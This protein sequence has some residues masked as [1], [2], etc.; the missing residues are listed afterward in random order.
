MR[1]G[2]TTPRAHYL[3]NLENTDTQLIS[4]LYMSASLADISAIAGHNMT[5]LD[6]LNTLQ[7]TE[8]LQE[9]IQELLTEKGL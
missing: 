2:A 4:A 8:K 1:K 6:L 9:Y 7:L 3:D 5:E